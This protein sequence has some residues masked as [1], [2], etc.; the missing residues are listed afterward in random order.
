MNTN[1]TIVR[2]D[3]SD[4]LDPVALERLYRLTPISAAVIAA[5][6]PGAAAVAQ[7][8]EA[9]GLAIEEI[10]VTAT[11]RAMPLQDVAQSIEAF[12]QADIEK[13]VLNDMEAYTRAAPSATLTASRPGKNVLTMRGISTSAEEWRTESRVAIYLDEQPITSISNQPDV[14]MVDIERIEILPGPQGTLLGSSSLSG[15][16]RI[17]TNKPNFDGFS[18][19]AT[20]VIGTTKG[21]DPSYDVNGVL[22][23]PLVDDKL[24]MRVVAYA[25]HEGGYV[26]NVLQE[27]TSG[28][29]SGLTGRIDNREFVEDNQNVYEIYGGRISALWQLSEDWHADFGAIVQTSRSEGSWQSDDLLGDYKVARFHDEWRDDDWWQVSATFTGDLGFAQFTST[30]SYFERETA[31]EFD[32]MYYNQWQTA[33]YGVWGQNIVDNY[34]IYYPNYTPW[35]ALFA[36]RYHWEYEWGHIYNDAEQTRFA[37]EFRLTSTTDS[38]F[39]WM[40]G[41]FYDDI[42][43]T[44]LYGSKIPGASDTIGWY[45]ASYWSCYYASLENGENWNC[46]I[47]PSDTTYVNNYKK[48]IKQTAVFGE[49]D[50]AFTDRL[51]GTIGA[52][53]FQYD[54]D[55]YQNSEAP[56]GMIPVLSY[57]RGFYQ[58]DFTSEGKDDG[59]LFKVSLKYDL[60]DD[61][62]VYATRSEG[63]RLGGY[64]APKAVA[65]GFVP[66]VY[67]ADELVNYELGLK[68]S[69]FD[70]R[71]RL[72]LALFQIDYDGIQV[73]SVPPDVVDENGDPLA[74]SPW[75]LRGTFNAGAG[76]NKGFEFNGSWLATRD[77]SFEW[78]V[79]RGDATFTED[80]WLT[81]DDRIA[82]PDDPWFTSG[83]KMAQ[84]PELKYR[85][86]VEYN[87]PQAFGW[88][89]DLFFRYDE[90]FQDD[91]FRRPE[92]WDDPDEPDAIVP[93]W[94]TA[95]FQAGFAFENGWSATLFVR[96]VWDDKA[97]NYLSSYKY[98]YENSPGN[99]DRGLQVMERTL[100]KP[101]TTSL[102]IS[103]KF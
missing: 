86:A 47:P 13:M 101:R 66:E 34:A 77:L 10:V 25:A 26:D 36:L 58:S 80:A 8:A 17:I 16:M 41:A 68:S 33:Y 1:D 53:W 6:T 39:Q 102:M 52:R 32:N 42:Y 9:G 12:S 28:V 61:A 85:W 93:S 60:T 2:D 20:A 70:N 81:E 75:W 100:Q 84:S 82:N 38:K 56:A 72:N 43:D 87:I 24:A 19:D 69:W 63:F 90:S 92:G 21:G 22:N 98:W 88:D 3:H 57:G 23:F 14:R 51:V 50:Y 31:Y 27:T 55:E 67:L 62:M 78:S 11:K 73:N 7:D 5:I 4:G 94:R 71:L 37:Q 65:T 91:S 96:N 40:L 95:N 97:S 89:G 46:P 29:P 45:W 49:F 64:N 59:T 54:R 30:T 35:G 74:R 103:K 44:W 76:E 15:A 79:Y 48:W 99:A 83:M 18:G